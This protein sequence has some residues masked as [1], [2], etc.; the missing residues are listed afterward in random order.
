MLTGIAHAAVCVGDVEAATEWYS[1]VLGLDVL[2]PPFELVGEAIERDMGELIPSPVIVRAAILGL[3][4]DDRVLELIEY[5]GK[6]VEVEQT[7]PV[8][9]RQGLTH[10]GLICDD[11]DRTRGEL[12]G[13]GVVFLTSG[14]ADVAG[15]R[16]T[17][18][19]DPWGTVFIL[20]QKDHE[21]RPYWRQFGR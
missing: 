3:G 16:T 14:I 13:R 9:V 17:W 8:I 19:R 5:P 18:F 6:A 2:S 11:I 12:E 10:V 20:L 7:P 15:L 1:Q 4:A 21:D